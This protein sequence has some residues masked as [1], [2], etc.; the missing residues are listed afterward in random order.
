MAG[1]CDLDIIV[2]EAAR[3]GGKWE[4]NGRKMGGREIKLSVPE[5]QGYVGRLTHCGLETFIER[6][7]K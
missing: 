4:E 5:R 7:V 1:S 2:D 6:L 3:L